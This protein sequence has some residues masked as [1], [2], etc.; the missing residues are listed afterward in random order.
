MDEAIR[1][2]VKQEHYVGLTPEDLRLNVEGR[3]LDVLTKYGG[4]RIVAGKVMHDLVQDL[5]N[6]VAKMKEDGL[7]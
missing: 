7:V 5:A 1:H 3:L 2:R 4:K 6:E